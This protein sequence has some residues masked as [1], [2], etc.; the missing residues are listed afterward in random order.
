MSGPV[1][2]SQTRAKVEVRQGQKFEFS[3][4]LQARGLCKSQIE[5]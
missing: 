4:R 3:A 1:Y 5:I 2:I